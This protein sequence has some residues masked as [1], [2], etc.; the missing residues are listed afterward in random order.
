MAQPDG[1]RLATMEA[2]VKNTNLRLSELEK[3]VQG[4]HGKFDTLTKILTENYV[5][6]DTFEEFKKNKWL[7]RVLIVLVTT[8]VSGLVAFFLREA[9]V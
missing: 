5:A 4:L 8:M 9:G 3:S 2:E 1:E 7:E 6:K